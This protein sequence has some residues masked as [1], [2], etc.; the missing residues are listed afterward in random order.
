MLNIIEMALASSYLSTL[1]AA[2]QAAG[3][4]QMLS[5]P[6]PFT[7][8][9]P[10]EEAFAKLP[11]GSV[12]DLLKDI[13]KLQE[14]LAYHIVEGSEMRAELVQQASMRTLHGRKISIASN[15]GIKVNQA[16]LVEADIACE[17]GVIHIIDAVLM[18]PT[19][20]FTVA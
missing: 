7:I 6:G 8:F 4:S 16:N 19:I 18:M 17:N 13:P 11:V 5:Q 14:M 2:I 1:H 12:E 15:N 3:W 10:N 20:K 9:A